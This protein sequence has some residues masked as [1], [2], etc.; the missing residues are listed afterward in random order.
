MLLWKTM[1]AETNNLSLRDFERVVLEPV[2]D[3]KRVV[4]LRVIAFPWTGRPLEFARD[5]SA[6][7]AERWEKAVQSQFS[8]QL[9][10]KR[11]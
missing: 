7:E 6:A 4:G 8:R 3:G 5:V 9:R 2:S 10:K 1:R 11:R